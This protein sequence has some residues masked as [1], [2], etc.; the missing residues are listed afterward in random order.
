MSRKTK[1][2]AQKLPG[3]FGIAP[4]LEKKGHT[5]KLEET[6]IAGQRRARVLTVRP[7]DRYRGRD[8]ISDEQWAAA[9]RVGSDW[10]D[11]CRGA[12]LTGLYG[13]RISGMPSQTEGAMAARERVLHIIR[14]MSRR[15][16]PILIHVCGLELSGSS[17]AALAGEPERSGLTILRFALDDLLDIYRAKRPKKPP[18]ID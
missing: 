12:R 7:I 1:R 6:M 17:W 18:P 14:N 13:I 4:V 3:E 8:L 15:L 11:G 10:Y 2:R 16:Y 9:D 5:V